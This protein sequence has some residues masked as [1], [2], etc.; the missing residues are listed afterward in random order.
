MLAAKIALG[1]LAGGVA[2]A[3][4]AYSMGVV[5]FLKSQPKQPKVERKVEVS[6]LGWDFIID[7][8][9]QNGSSE[10]NLDTSYMGSLW[11]IW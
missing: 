4:G 5:P 1:L 9:T 10:N 3:G 6:D 2:M 11:A 8:K 7:W